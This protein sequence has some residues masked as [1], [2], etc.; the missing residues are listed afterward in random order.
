MRRL[1]ATRVRAILGH[2]IKCPCG[3]RLTERQIA[4]AE[5]RGAEAKYCCPK[6]RD[7]YGKRE[8]RAKGKD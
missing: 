7:K 6:C 3:K 1:T 8:R 2:M 5:S 4:V